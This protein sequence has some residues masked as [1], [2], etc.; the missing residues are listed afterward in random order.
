MAVPTVTSVCA[1]AALIE[2]RTRQ[3]LAA[4]ALERFYLKHARYPAALQEL[5]PEFA[6][7]VSLDPWDGKELRYRMT[8]GGRYTLWCVGMDGKD[9]GGQMNKNGVAM[10]SRTYLGDWTWQYEPVK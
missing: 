7:A 5:V 3:A 8:A 2:A 1:N 9:D 6:A 4:I 10:R